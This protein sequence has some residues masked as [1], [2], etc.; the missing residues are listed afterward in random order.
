MKEKIAVIF[1]HGKIMLKTFFYKFRE[2][3]KQ[4]EI[5]LYLV[6]GALTTAVDWVISFVLYSIWGEGIKSNPILIHVANAVAW[7][8][9]VLFAFVTNRIFVF[10]SE[11][12]GKGILAELA[13]F[14]GGRVLTL[15]LQEALFAVFFN[16][17]G[18][19]EYAVKIGAAVIVVIL[20]YIFGKLIFRTRKKDNENNGENADGFSE[21][22]DG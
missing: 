22:S 1:R 2:K 20:N 7:A 16:W 9:A 17:L 12:K 13:A 3:L 4:P 5:W 15:L 21:V 11:R 14:T 8:A 6:F 18:L 19:N 10:R